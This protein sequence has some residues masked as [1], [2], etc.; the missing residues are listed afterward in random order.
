MTHHRGASAFEAAIEV[1]ESGYVDA[2]GGSEIVDAA[3]SGARASHISTSLDQVN[4]NANA[5]G[6]VENEICRA[7][8]RPPKDSAQASAYPIY[9]DPAFCGQSVV[10]W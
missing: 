6:E 2:A 3:Q 10:N 9:L 4:A 7:V 1:E 8:S 5:S